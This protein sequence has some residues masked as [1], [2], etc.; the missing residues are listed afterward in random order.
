MYKNVLIYRKYTKQYS[1]MIRHHISD[2]LSKGLGKGSLH[3]ACNFSVNFRMKTIQSV[4]VC[5]YDNPRQHIIKKQRHHFANKS[6]Y[7]QSY[8][9]SSSHVWMWEL[10]D[11]EGWAPKNWCFRIVVLEKTIEVSLDCKEIKSVNPK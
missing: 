5:V 10:K 7:C 6:L 3:Y 8:G 4:C 9:F 11:K 1:K 2:L